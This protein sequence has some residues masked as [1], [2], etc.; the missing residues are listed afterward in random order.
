MQKPN[1]I[2]V[3][4]FSAM[5][6]VAMTVPVLLGLVHHNPDLKITVVT[7]PSY[8]A[9]FDG[10]PNT[11][12]FTANL[13]V[14]YKGFR[15]LFKL[16]RKLQKLDFDAIAD[17]HNVIRTAILKLLLPVKMK[18]TIDKG[19]REK[20][21][22]VTG[23]EFK[24]LKTTIA[25]Y[26][27]VFEKLGYEVDISTPRFLQKQ[28]LNSKIKD[29]ISPKEF[30]TIG[31]APFAAHKGKMYPLGQM[32]EVVKALAVDYRVLLFGGG[33]HENKILKELEKAHN[34]VFSVACKLSFREELDLISNLD[35]MLSMD[36]GNGHLAAMYGVKVVSI[37]G[38][39]HP[40]AGFTPFNQP[41]YHSLMPDRTKFPLIPTS[42][43]GNKYPEDYEDCAGSIP[44]ET[45]VKK[46][47][48]LLS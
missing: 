17:V 19:R 11:T 45:V 8:K 34:N 2:L 29:Y 43:Y 15:G 24:Q 10:I 32:K 9:I 35:L 40:Y 27:E 18:A 33:E 7:R 12:I 48:G 26:I 31:I 41:E 37:W 44:V 5:G 4:R 6:D 22:L 30:K 1:H 3:L 36:S 28:P 21:D 13:K 38:V 47:T 16:S 25:R 46:V 39:T 42:I 23:K 20:K 14:E